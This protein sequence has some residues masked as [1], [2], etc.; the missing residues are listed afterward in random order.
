MNPR[1]RAEFFGLAQRDLAETR[2]VA[3]YDAVRADAVAGRQP[4]ALDE[5]LQENIPI[6]DGR[7]NDLADL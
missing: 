5:V 1:D 7:D 4:A 3:D 6:V 2:L